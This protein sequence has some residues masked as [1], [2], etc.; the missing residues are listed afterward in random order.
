MTELNGI[1]RS[2]RSVRSRTVRDYV[3]IGFR[4]RRLIFLS[5]VAIFLGCVLAIVVIPPKYE[6]QTRILLDSSR[7]NPVISTKPEVLQTQWKL[8]EDELNTEME[9]LL[10]R[11]VLQKAVVGCSLYELDPPWTS[12]IAA[13]QVL[14]SHLMDSLGFTPDKDTRIY[15]ATLK[16]ESKIEVVPMPD[17]NI[18]QV[19]YASPFPDRSACV[20]HAVTQAYMDKHLH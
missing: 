6:A 8:S 7:V 14:Q 1:S 17:S 12:P 3:A 2:D 15:R 20:L 9:V 10:S 16:L 11:D 18:I 4:N 5:F 13:V 19:S